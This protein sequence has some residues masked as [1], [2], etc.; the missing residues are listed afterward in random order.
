M[1]NIK[2][3]VKNNLS[4]PDPTKPAVDALAVNY[5]GGDQT[6]AF[7]CRGI[8]VGGAGNLACR[9]VGASADVTF[10]GLSA[11]VVYPFA[12]SIIRQT[13]STITN[14]VVLF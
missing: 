5:G 14:S 12:I 11:G 8:F 10:T 13:N 1:P 9:L 3:V 7:P 2:A 4:A 6:L